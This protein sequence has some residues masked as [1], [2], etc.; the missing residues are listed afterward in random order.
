MD[1]ESK[2]KMNGESV[3]GTLNEQQKASLLQVILKSQQSFI[4]LHVEYIVNEF[5]LKFKERI[6]DCKLIDSCDDELVK[7]LIGRYHTFP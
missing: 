6:K 5:L 3:R 4:L 2:K 1:L 7:W